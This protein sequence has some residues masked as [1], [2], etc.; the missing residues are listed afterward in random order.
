MTNGIG[1]AGGCSQAA[2]TMMRPQ[3][4]DAAKQ[5]Q[6]LLA[7][8][9][10]NGDGGIDKTELKSFMDFVGKATSTEGAES[11]TLFKSLDADNDGAV[12]ADELTS[13]GK[14][15]F[16]Q[17]REQLMSARASA[18]SEAP[19][20]RDPQGMFAK[21][22]GNG[23]GS[24]DKS[25]LNTFFTQ[26]AEEG[27]SS[28]DD[29]LARDDADSDGA[30]SATEFETAVGKGPQSHHEQGDRGVA[31]RIEALLQQYVDG[32]AASQATNSMTAIA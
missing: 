19:Q 18:G 13:N 20:R 1:A 15:L 14:A 3:A 23:D 31:M 16:D 27:G 5:S 29:I 28:V 25:E 10:T 32:G 11:D 6:Q 24:I 8:L 12:S 9:D 17:L 22:D 30:I 7:K 4:P 2:M 21:I 26:R